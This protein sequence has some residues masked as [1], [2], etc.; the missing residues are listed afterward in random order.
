MCKSSAGL[1]PALLCA[2]LALLPLAQAV[3]QSTV[4]GVVRDSTGNPVANAEVSVLSTSQAART[5][6]AGHFAI[7][8]LPAGSYL[9]LTRRLGYR[10][11][12][13]DLVVTDSQVPSIDI[14][15]HAVAVELA[16]VVAR[17]RLE[18]F[19]PRLTA[20]TERGLSGQYRRSQFI[21]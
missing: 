6:S 14:E 16:A 8:A 18:G 11:D 4:Q 17:A 3:A 7:G 2:V 21:T 12:L 9:L 5:D 15:L 20:M 19:D 1:R 13:R 10:Q